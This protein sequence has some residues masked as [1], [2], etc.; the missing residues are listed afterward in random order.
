MQYLNLVCENDAFWYLLKGAMLQVT[1]FISNT[2]T[3][4]KLVIKC[5]RKSWEDWL[6][7]LLQF[8]AWEDIWSL[9]SLIH[10][11]SL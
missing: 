2:M 6:E 10:G 9:I 5:P 7:G 3:F 4:G 1:I 8:P 11:I